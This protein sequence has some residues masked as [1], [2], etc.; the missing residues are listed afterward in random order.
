[1]HLKEAKAKVKLKHFIR[2]REKTH[3]RASKHHFHGVIKA[4]ASQTEKAKRGDA[5]NLFY[6]LRLRDLASL[7]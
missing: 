4:M 3:P 1:M 5:E 2:E 7:R 6:T